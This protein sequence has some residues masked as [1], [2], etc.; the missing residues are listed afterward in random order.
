MVA[1]GVVGQNYVYTQTEGTAAP[2]ELLESATTTI[3]EAPTGTGDS[4]PDQMSSWNVLPFAW[5]FYGA[6]VGG[7]YVS[8]NGYIAF[9]SSASTPLNDTLPNVGGPN[10]AI[11]AFWDDIEIKE[12]A[13]A[14]DKVK[15]WTY[16]QSPN[17]VHVISVREVMVCCII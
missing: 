14:V 9:D 1:R 12:G 4:L 2:Y 10:N 17:R 13:N 11:Y 5:A 3:M 8:D 7:Y 6:S 15:S 16:G